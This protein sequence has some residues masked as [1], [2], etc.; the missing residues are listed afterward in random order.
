MKRL[1][2]RIADYFIP[3]GLGLTSVEMIKARVLINSCFLA[4]TLMMLSGLNRFFLTDK[5]PSSVLYV[6]V[7][8]FIIPWTVKNLGS[9]KLVSFLFPTLALIVLPIMTYY[10]G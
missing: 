4:S 9:F 7:V 10:R 6:T 5:F 8:L 1:F 2:D 3:K